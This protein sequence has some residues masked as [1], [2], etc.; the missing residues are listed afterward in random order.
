MKIT[1][2][3]IAE[4]PDEDPVKMAQVQLQSAKVV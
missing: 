1:D 4:A 3:Q 2:L